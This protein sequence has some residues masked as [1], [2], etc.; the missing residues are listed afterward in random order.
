MCV[1]VCV[2]MCRVFI[3]FNVHGEE[4]KR[5][6]Q[7]AHSQSSLRVLASRGVILNV[8]LKRFPLEVCLD[9]QK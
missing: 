7:S 9:A 1:C 6:F 8:I 5:N 2:S 3:Y 4:S